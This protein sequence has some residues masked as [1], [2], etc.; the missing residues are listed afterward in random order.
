MFTHLSRQKRAQ[1]AR[2]QRTKSN[3]RSNASAP[4]LTFFRSSFCVGQQ[5]EVCIFILYYCIF[6]PLFGL[7]NQSYFLR[8]RTKIAP[9]LLEFSSQNH[10]YLHSIRIFY[11]A[12]M[13]KSHFYSINSPTKQI[14]RIYFH[15]LVIFGFFDRFFHLKNV[16]IS[17]RFNSF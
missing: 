17:V 1:S 2:N 11:N 6:T 10:A 7:A 4:R 8:I 12:N 5:N 16:L 14:A 3:K 13:Q 9:I 15:L